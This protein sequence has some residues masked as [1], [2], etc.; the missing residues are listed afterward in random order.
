VETLNRCNHPE[1]H[2]LS[3]NASE[4][5]AVEA[6]RDCPCCGAQ[7][8][9]NVPSVG[10]ILDA[11]TLDGGCSVPDLDV[12][13]ARRERQVLNVL[14]RS[15]Y[16]L[17]HEQLAALVWSDRNRTH[18]VRSVLYRLRCK[19]R[20]SGWAIPF[21]AEGKGVRLVPEATQPRQPQLRATAG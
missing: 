13:L 4:A 19:L 11:V 9:I 12:E 17:R 3:L 14:H 8:W 1:G 7:L 18:E 5:S 16:A 2:E 20:N 6:C 21:P 10:A 15:Q